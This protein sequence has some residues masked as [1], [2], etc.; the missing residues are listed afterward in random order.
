MLHA[1]HTQGAVRHAVSIHF[2]VS[3]IDPKSHLDYKSAKSD[4]THQRYQGDVLRELYPQIQRGRMLLREEL[5]AA[6]DGLLVTGS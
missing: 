2:R 5:Q 4:V 1:A 6:N 3:P